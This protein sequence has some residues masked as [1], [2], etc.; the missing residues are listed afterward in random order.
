MVGG[1][2]QLKARSESGKKRG[3]VDSQPYTLASAP[4]ALAISF[5]L[6]CQGR[7]GTCAD[8]IIVSSRPH[9]CSA[10]SRA[11]EDTGSIF[12]LQCDIRAERWL[13]TNSNQAIVPVASGYLDICSSGERNSA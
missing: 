3:N 13:L 12:A 10:L 1:V 2:G 6:R 8:K 9:Q 5:L 7:T 4:E 11:S